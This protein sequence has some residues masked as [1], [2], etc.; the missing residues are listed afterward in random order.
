MLRISNLYI[1]PIKSM[2]GIPLDTARV[3]DRG[4]EYDRRWML[5]DENNIQLTQREFPLMALLQPTFTPD[6]LTVTY[7]PANTQL[8]IS[9]QPRTNN[10]TEVR[11]WDDICRAQFVNP[12]AD[13]WFSNILGTPC[14]LVYMPETT[15]RQTDLNYTPEG[16]ITS[17]SDGYPFLLIGQSS[18]DELNSRLE[19]PL[20]MDRFRPN[21]VFTGGE[22]FEEDQ[23]HDFTI[24][25]IRFS[26]VKLC[27]R[28][29]I[30]TTDQQTAKRGKEPL[31]TLA[32]WRAK[33]NKILFGQNLIHHGLG[34]LTV[35]DELVPATP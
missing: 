17:F 31:R 25:A 3:T 33:D 32:T 2:G 14:R 28:C 18:L 12:E 13:S 30:T 35:G 24:G 21:I 10:Y 11:C 1:Y 7:R 26:G 16:H 4:L 19:Q 5:I 27:A 9:F 34:Q 8:S 6:G 20:P 29:V 22:P 23:L 15:M